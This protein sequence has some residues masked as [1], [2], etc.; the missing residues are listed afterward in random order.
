MVTPAR[1]R[2]P[3]RLDEAR[4]ENKKR[5]AS[6]PHDPDAVPSRRPADDRRPVTR[7]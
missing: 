4:A 5:T 2:A 1:E 6:E 7:S 3:D